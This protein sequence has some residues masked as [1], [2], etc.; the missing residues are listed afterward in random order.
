M[1]ELAQ[2]IV[3]VVL[4][5]TSPTGDTKVGAY[6]GKD[7]YTNCTKRAISL[8]EKYYPYKLKCEYKDLD[9]QKNKE[10]SRTVFDEENR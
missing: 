6:F 4:T 1:F 7:A 8:E 5:S 10:K 9:T 3:I 2:V